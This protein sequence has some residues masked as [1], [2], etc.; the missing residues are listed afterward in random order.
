ML[1]IVVVDD[2]FGETLGEEALGEGF[3][4]LNQY[5]VDKTV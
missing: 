3:G 4:V 1:T 5:Q 2:G